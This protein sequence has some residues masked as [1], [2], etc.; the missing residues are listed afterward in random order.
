MND[1]KIWYKSKRVWRTIFSAALAVLSVLPII[2]GIINDQW[3]SETLAWATAQLVAVQAVVTRIMAIEK[4]N[5]WLSW[6]GLGSAPK[7]VL[8]Q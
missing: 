2:L 3:P 8:E 6:I 4:V 5:K 7:D 1:D